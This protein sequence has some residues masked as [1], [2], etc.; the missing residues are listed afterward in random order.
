MKVNEN[1]H[2]QRRHPK[3]E[4]RPSTN[5]T[6]MCPKSGLPETL[7]QVQRFA[8]RMP[9]RLVKPIVVGQRD[10]RTSLKVAPILMQ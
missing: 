8:M 1:L 10:P 5:C 9:V 2:G 4:V 6:S 7:N 3:V